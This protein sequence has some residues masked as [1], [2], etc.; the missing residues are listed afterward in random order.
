MTQTG[1]STQLRSTAEELLT[2]APK[3]V[4]PVPPVDELLHELQVHQ[5]ELQMQNEELRHAQ[6]ALEE[7]RNRYQDLYEFA[8]VGYLTINAHGVVQEINLT[9]A[10]LLK[11]N[12]KRIVAHHLSRFIASED[13]DRYHRSFQQLL[14]HDNRQTFDM[15]LLRGD[16]S[17]CHTQLDCI[18]VA[19]SDILPTVRI[20][21]TDITERKRAEARIEKLAFYDPLT[22]L[23]NRRLLLDRLQQAL[24]TSV[25]TQLQVRSSL[26]ILMTSRP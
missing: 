1:I 21:L 20:T 13:K 5:I 14:K 8:P 22:Q 3:P 6:L 2:H 7:A 15:A 26:S 25:R 24:P 10:I 12:R 16:G 11:E 4:Q 19:D 9:G 18:R 23:P 17:I